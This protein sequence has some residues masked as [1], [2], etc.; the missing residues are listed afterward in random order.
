MKTE[1]KLEYTSH[2]Q[3]IS[4]YVN[5]ARLYSDATVQEITWKITSY[6]VRI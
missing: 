2:N 3:S 6:R 1:V 4:Q 5:R